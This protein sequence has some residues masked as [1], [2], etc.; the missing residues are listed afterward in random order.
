MK[1]L[2]AKLLVKLCIK[3]NEEDKII[4]IYHKNTMYKVVI[5]PQRV[6]A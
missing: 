3:E 6:C 2:L 1:R 5:K 4:D